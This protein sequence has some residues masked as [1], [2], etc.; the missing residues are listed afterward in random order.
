M[1]NQNLYDLYIQPIK[2]AK[3]VGVI[4]DATRPYKTEKAP[5]FTT[6]IKIIDNTLNITTS[7]INNPKKYIHVFIY[8]KT[9][10]E[11]PDITQVGDII[12]L[13]HFDVF[14]FK[15]FFSKKYQFYFYSWSFSVEIMK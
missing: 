12:Y 10:K 9:L 2:K 8:S 14:F 11:S 3:L 13:R 4:V 15:N 5:D 7:N 1:R 6:K